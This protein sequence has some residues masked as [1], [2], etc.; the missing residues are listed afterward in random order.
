MR[1]AAMVPDPVTGRLV[2][3]L[4]EAGIPIE[5]DAESQDDANRLARANKLP[6]AVLVLGD[7]LA[8]SRA[9]A[10]QRRHSPASRRFP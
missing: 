7:E 9:P 4:G 6:P 8:G 10:Q 5:F 1:F 2:P 3:Y